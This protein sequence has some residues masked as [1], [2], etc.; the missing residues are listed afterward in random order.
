MKGRKDRREREGGRKEG[1]KEENQGSDKLSSLPEWSSS[2]A[3]S[4]DLNAD[5]LTPKPALLT[6]HS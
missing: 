6:L 3:Q 2:H 1:G 5:S 4:V